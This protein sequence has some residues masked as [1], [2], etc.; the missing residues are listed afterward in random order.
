MQAV[1]CATQNFMLSLA[2]DGVGSKW[3]TGALGAA[4]EDVLKAVDVDASK[5]KLIGAIWYGFPAKALS[6]GA[7]SPPRKLGLAGTRKDLP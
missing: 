7:K 1:A 5:E 6:A 2:E 3:M 4:P